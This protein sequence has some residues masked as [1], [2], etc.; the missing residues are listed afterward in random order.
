MVKLTWVQQRMSRTKEE[1]SWSYAHGGEGCHCLGK[2][3]TQ[4]AGTRGNPVHEHCKLGW[5]SG[6]YRNLTM[7]RPWALTLQEWPWSHNLDS[8]LHFV[9]PNFEQHPHPFS[10]SSHY[11][12]KFLL[13]FLIQVRA[14]LI[15]PLPLRQ[16]SG[17]LRPGEIPGCTLG[18]AAALPSLGV[19][20]AQAAPVFSVSMVLAFLNL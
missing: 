15:S 13:H 20:R 3:G 11:Q 18:L 17:H 6:Q 7:D 9:N 16:I 19:E 5:I 10:F 12:G 14:W 1:S 2:P 8:V 4:T